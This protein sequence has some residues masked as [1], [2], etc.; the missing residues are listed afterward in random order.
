MRSRRSPGD[1]SAA[2][3]QRELPEV[4]GGQKRRPRT[5]LVAVGS[6]LCARP[7][8]DSCR[9]NNGHRSSGLTFDGR[10]RRQRGLQVEFGDDTLFCRR[11][12][13]A[14]ALRHRPLRLQLALLA[15]RHCHRFC[16]R[17]CRAGGAWSGD[18]TRAPALHQLSKRLAGL[19]VESYV[20]AGTR[21]NIRALPQATEP[22]RQRKQYTPILL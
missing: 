16:R 15:C 18:R 22:A 17:R 11:A 7:P 12:L 19:A 9:G 20:T 10:L 8:A 5:Q 4:G 3:A 21:V 2:R 6:G 1:R 13:V 14:R